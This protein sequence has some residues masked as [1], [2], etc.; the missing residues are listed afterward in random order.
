MVSKNKNAQALQAAPKAA[1]P[2][3]NAQPFVKWAGGKR[4]VAP[5]ALPLLEPYLRSGARY[6]EPFIG[7]GAIFFA[8]RWPEAVINDANPALM[9]AYRSIRDNVG[10]LIDLL[11]LIARKADERAYYAIR[12]R[13]N[14]IHFG[15]TTNGSPRYDIDTE[16]AAYFLYLNRTGYNGLF[17]VNK[18]GAFNVPFG[19]YK[20]PTVCDE[21]NLRAASTFL[22]HT[23]IRAGD[24]ELALSSVRRG[25]VVY[26]DP[27]YLPASQTANF[28]SYT[29]DGFG[30]VEHQRLF[31][32]MRQM[33][34]RGAR[35]VMSQADS[36]YI[37]QLAETT[38]GESPLTVL[39]I[40]VRRAINSDGDK[41]GHVPE[42]LI[43]GGG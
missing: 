5:F 27:P 26:L 39:P 30:P 20:N 8:L 3:T 29:K 11:R 16:F 19:D 40:Q 9:N 23:D 42:L 6:F 33:I 14:D 38:S 10:G 15:R 17:R 34:A 25:D 35:C 18:S 32:V 24:F 7:G 37:R 1:E 43:F 13:Y 31:R 28:A 12:E 21:S 36:P 41:R 2:V 22:A 4:S